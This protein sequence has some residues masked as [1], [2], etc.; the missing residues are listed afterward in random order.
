MASH[1]IFGLVDVSRQSRLEGASSNLAQIL[2]FKDE[3]LAV[4]GQRSQ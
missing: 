4:T 3:N 1:I 2:T